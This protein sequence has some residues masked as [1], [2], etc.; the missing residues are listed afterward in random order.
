VAEVVVVVVVAVVLVV[1]V[2]VVVVVVAATAVYEDQETETIYH[3]YKH[4]SM[5]HLFFGAVGKRSCKA[6]H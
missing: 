6:L 3:L 5:A 2:V 4:T 1:V